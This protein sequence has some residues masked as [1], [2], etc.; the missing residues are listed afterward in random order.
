MAT[1]DRLAASLAA[2]HARRA[3]EGEDVDVHDPGPIDH[4]REDEADAEG[5]AD[6]FRRSRESSLSRAQL[7]DYAQFRGVRLT[8]EEQ[9]APMA[10]LRK[11]ILERLASIA[12]H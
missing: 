1:A 3:D 10:E 9:S 11:V 12:R 6:S 4:D 7:V 8:P 5:L 2:I